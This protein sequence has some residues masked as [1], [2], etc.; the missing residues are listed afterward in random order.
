MI[1]QEETREILY[2]EPQ[3]KMKREEEMHKTKLEAMK[4]SDMDRSKLEG[5]E[6]EGTEL[7]G[8]DLMDMKDTQHTFV[9]S[10]P[11]WDSWFMTL[12][13]LVAQRSLDKHTKCGCVVVDDSNT[14]LSV[15]YNSPPRGCADAFVPLERPEK[16]D[17]MKHSE[18]NAI[19]NAARTG[20]CLKGSTF[21]ITGPPCH[22]CFGDMINVG[23]KKIV[24]GPVA[25][26]TSGS[27]SKIIDFMKINQ[28]IEIIE[29]KDISSVFQLLSKTEEY[30]SSKMGIKK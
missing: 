19:I 27:E 24:H 8:A 11:D 7:E 28:S 21:Y 15:G 23:V 4:G 17:Y 18:E 10:R 3:R 13:F 29:I 25:H 6:L 26:S 12:C 9:D 2:H 22:G 20:I 5:T 14:I 30:I 16:Y 1:S